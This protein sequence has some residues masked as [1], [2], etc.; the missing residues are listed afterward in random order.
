LLTRALSGDSHVDSHLLGW[1]AE[2]PLDFS[3]PRYNGKPLLRFLDAYALAV[4]GEL[5]RADEPTVAAAVERALG[6][7]DDWKA[8]VR[9]A[10]GLPDDFDDRIRQLWKR[11]PSGT[12]TIDFVLA[13]SDANFAPLIDPVPE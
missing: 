10:A 11:Q 2:L 13:I 6:R 8:S 3:A 4:I 7:T 1:V 9:S 5:S 12:G